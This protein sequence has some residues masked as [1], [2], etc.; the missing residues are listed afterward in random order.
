MD[1]WGGVN[2]VV[3]GFDVWVT[4]VG[5]GVLQY[6]PVRMEWGTGRSHIVNLNAG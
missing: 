2:V 1:L 3:E 4:G 6:W 5:H